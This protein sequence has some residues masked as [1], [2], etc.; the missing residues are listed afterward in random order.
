MIN[1]DEK[2]YIERKDLINNRPPQRNPDQTGKEEYNKGYNDGIKAVL[3]CREIQPS[4]PSIFSPLSYRFKFFVTS[5]DVAPVRHA[6]WVLIDECVN[7]GI[8]CS[9][10]HKK[11]YRAEYA[12]QKV[13]SNFCPNC[14]AKMDEE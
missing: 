2:E 7:E 9:N 5:A 14:G 3:S 4:I 8:Y 1:K 13:K 6:K 10:C 12:N 11:I